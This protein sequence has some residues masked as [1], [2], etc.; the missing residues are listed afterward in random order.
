MSDLRST[1]YLSTPSTD[2]ADDLLHG[3]GAIAEFLGVNKRR[4]YHLH[5]TRV[6]PSFNLGNVV[7]ARRSALRQHIARLEATAMPDTAA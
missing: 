2:L 3:A 4:V 6:I 1:T 7:C 5:E